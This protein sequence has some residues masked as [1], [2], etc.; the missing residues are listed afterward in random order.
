[1]SRIPLGAWARTLP[2]RR[3][4]PRPVPHRLRLPATPQRPAAIRRRSCPTPH[5]RFPPPRPILH[6]P[7]RAR[8]IPRE[9]P[10]LGSFAAG[11]SGKGLSLRKP[12]KLERLWERRTRRA[13]REVYGVGG[14]ANAHARTL[15]AS[16]GRLIDKATI[17]AALVLVRK[18]PRVGSIGSTDTALRKAA[19]PEAGQRWQRWRR[20]PGWEPGFLRGAPPATSVEV[21]ATTAARR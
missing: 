17:T 1:L 3:Q 16:A 15:R 12:A 10:T 9:W 2:K 19:W 5:H 14:G 7:G 18:A 4:Q 21:T 11:C 13:A 6:M 20:T 8:L